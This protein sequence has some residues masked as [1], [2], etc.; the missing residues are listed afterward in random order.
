ME[1]SLMHSFSHTHILGLWGICLDPQ[2]GS[3]Y[4]VMPF[5]EH[6]DLR[7]FLLKKADLTDGSGS[8]TTYPQV[9][10]V[11]VLCVCVCVHA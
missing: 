11:C 5:M 10:C 3:P 2:T 9:K 4:L 6:G 1:S 8:V 7:N